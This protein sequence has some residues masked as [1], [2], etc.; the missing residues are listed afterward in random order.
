MGITSGWSGPCPLRVPVRSAAVFGVAKYEDTELDTV[1]ICAYTE[2]MNYEWDPA[3]AAGNLRKHRVD[4]ADAV[5]ALEDPLAVTVQ[6]DRHGEQRFVTL[7]QDAEG[8]LL[9]VAYAWQEQTIRII[10]ARRATRHER[11]EYEG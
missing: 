4:F 3:K 1:H 11:M 10:S 2:F 7:G 6:D 5:T 8:H 9:V